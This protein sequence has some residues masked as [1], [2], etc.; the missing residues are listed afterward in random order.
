[1]RRGTYL[2]TDV[3]SNGKHFLHSEILIVTQTT[4]TPKIIENNR[5]YLFQAAIIDQRIHNQLRL[6]GR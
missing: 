3:Y 1:M 6:I 2:L 4:T 5:N